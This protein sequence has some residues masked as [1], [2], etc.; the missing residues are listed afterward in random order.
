MGEEIQ[1]TGNTSDH[2][3]DN[4]FQFEYHCGKCNAGYKSQF[5]TWGTG[6]ITG[7]LNTAGGLF[8]GLFGSA[9]QVGQSVKSAQW[10]Q[11]HDAAF[12]EVQ[13]EL[14]PHFA[15]CPN[16]NTWVCRT[17]CWNL[18]SGLCKNCAPDLAVEMSAA[19]AA[20]AKEKA[21]ENATVS[22]EDDHF[23]KQDYQENIHAS[24]PHC[25]APLADHKA[26]FCPECGKKISE[27]I[28]CKKCDAKLKP[29]TKFCSECG[30]KV[31]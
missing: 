7:F 29:G 21:W 2:S 15:Q 28:K 27:E 4:G 5:K 13:K 23:T 18:K 3:S 9:A 20:K 17:R 19:Q 31:G 14:L 10:E 8:G 25:D 30:E 11:A 1:F 22:E 12:V 16:C 26:K 24:C 6:T